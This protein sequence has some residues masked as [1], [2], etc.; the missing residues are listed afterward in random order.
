M[1]K[2]L[3]AHRHNSKHAQCF[4][5]F[6]DQN[7]LIMSIFTLSVKTV[8]VLSGF[9]DTLGHFSDTFITKGCTK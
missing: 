6:H 3:G 2:S 9:S 7:C 8:R 4:Y 5:L 1:E